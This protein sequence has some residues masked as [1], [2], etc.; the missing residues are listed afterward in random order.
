MLTSSRSSIKLHFLTF[1]SILPVFN[2][3]ITVLI[4]DEDIF[5]HSQTAFA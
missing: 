5:I 4:T 1:F 2:V 3:E